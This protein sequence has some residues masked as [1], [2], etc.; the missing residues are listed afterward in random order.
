MT[1]TSVFAER[2]QIMTK[3]ASIALL[4]QKNLLLTMVLFVIVALCG[5]DGDNGTG[6]DSDTSS[7][8]ADGSSPFGTDIDSYCN[9]T[10]A[11]TCSLCR[12]CYQI[13]YTACF[14]PMRD[15][16]FESCNNSLEDGIVLDKAAI[17]ECLELG[18]DAFVDGCEYR[19]ADSTEYQQAL[20]VCREVFR[21]TN[22]VQKLAENS[23]C[24]NQITGECENGLFCDTS[25]Q[26]ARCVRLRMLGS[27]CENGL[28]CSSQICEQG[29][30]VQI[31][32]RE[33]CELLVSE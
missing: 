1:D 24:G 27:A 2:N 25:I 31:S 26:P 23:E 15:N 11:Q 7:V 5:C 14:E 9:D 18:L 6:L 28:Q 33:A 19:S 13:D 32:F 21:E 20:A 29:I 22:P 10:A 17:D 4:G 3:I 30:C 8:L 12:D 16:C